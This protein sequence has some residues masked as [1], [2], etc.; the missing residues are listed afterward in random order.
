MNADPTEDQYFKGALMLN[1][2]R[3]VIDDDPKW[4]ALIHDFYQHFKYQN[5]MT[6]DV[7]A[8]F[9]QH[10]GM[11]LTPIFNQ[12]LR[13]TQIPRLELLFG[14]APGMVMYKWDADE[15]DFAMPVRVGTPDHWQII[16]PTTKWQWMQTPLTKDRVPGGDG[17]LLRG[18]EQAI[19]SGWAATFMLR[20]CLLFLRLGGEAARFTLRFRSFSGGEDPAMAYPTN[21]RYTANTN[22]SRSTARSALLASPIMRRTRWAT[23]CMWTRPRWATR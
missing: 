18:C 1:T 7:V 13:H 17:S 12:Y 23:L 19:G 5:I 3:S 20:S 22:G 4:L 15:E 2:L 10:T 14:E 6:D 8:Y 9:N 11:N 16:H 21:Y